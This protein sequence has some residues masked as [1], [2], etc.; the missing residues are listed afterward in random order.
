MESMIRIKSIMVGM[1]I[2]VYAGMP[3]IADDIEIYTTAKLASCGGATECH[4]HRGHIRQHE[5]R[6][7]SAE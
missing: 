6:S 5:R 7:D 1:A 3:A 2:A 4:V